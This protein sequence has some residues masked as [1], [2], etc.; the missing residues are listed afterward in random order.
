MRLLSH[1]TRKFLTE[2]WWG[3]RMRWHRSVLS[4]FHY[5]KGQGQLH[6]VKGLIKETSWQAAIKMIVR[7]WFYDTHWP[8]L[9]GRHCD[10]QSRYQSMECISLHN[11]V[12]ISFFR[13]EYTAV[14]LVFNLCRQ[15]IGN[16]LI[17]RQLICYRNLSGGG[18][19]Q[20]VPASIVGV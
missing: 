20:L 17:Y 10:L 15:F 9:S 19:V 5:P 8:Q 11:C 14:A 12:N 3:R 18:G 4:L 6:K 7:W 1:E 16:L 13:Q 2:N